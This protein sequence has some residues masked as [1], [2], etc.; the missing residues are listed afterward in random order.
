MERLLSIGTQD[1][2]TY[3]YGQH[4]HDFWE[5]TYYTDG[6]GVNITGGVAYP[7]KA[8]TI[9]CQPPH[10]VHEDISEKGYK[11]IFFEVDS[12][13][14]DR[15]PLVISDND[16]KS[17][18]KV[19]ELMYQEY[20]ED[21]DPNMISSFIAIINSYLMRWSSQSNKNTYVEEMKREIFF[22][23]SSTDFN[24]SDCFRKMP[25]SESQLR[26]YFKSETGMTPQ[27]YLESIRIRQ[28][29]K[30]LLFDAYTVSQIGLM[31]GYADPYYFSRAF[32]KNTGMSPSEYRSRRKKKKP[33]GLS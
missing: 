22:N 31:C 28:A 15:G 11:N 32:K 26:R 20:F 6:A 7:F 13:F 33:S 5:I 3:A 4:Q 9:I 12:F 14:C 18:L 17:F 25:W 1:V 2:I 10:V 8:G 16:S 21:N 30:F 19:V 24:V 29:K 23:Y 27:S